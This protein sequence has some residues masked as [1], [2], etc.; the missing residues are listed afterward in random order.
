[1]FA[2]PKSVQNNSG[3]SLPSLPIPPLAH[4]LQQLAEYVVPL[5]DVSGEEKRALLKHLRETI[6][7][8]RPT[9]RAPTPSTTTNAPPSAVAA[10]VYYQV[11][12]LTHRLAYSL[13][14]SLTHPPTHSDCTPL[15]QRGQKMSVRIG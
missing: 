6:A 12:L 13:T 9:S 7:A 4:T 14:H 15:S 2:A 1:M 10:A 3:H 5:D 11:P 8:L